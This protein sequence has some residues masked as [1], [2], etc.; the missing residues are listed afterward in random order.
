VT[1]PL[2]LRA[3]LPL[4]I[5]QRKTTLAKSLSYGTTIYQGEQSLRFNDHRRDDQMERLSTILPGL[6]S[7]K[8]Q[9]WATAMSRSRHSIRRMS[10]LTTTFGT[11]GVGNS[12]KE[13]FA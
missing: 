12:L 3:E 13:S 6:L 11:C 10:K 7:L 2:L 4:E 8:L 5:E 1:E 9:V